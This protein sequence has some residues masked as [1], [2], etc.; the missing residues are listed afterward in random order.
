MC[1]QK[2]DQTHQRSGG[3]CCKGWEGKKRAK[4]ADKVNVEY[5]NTGWCVFKKWIQNQKDFRLNINIPKGTLWIL[6]IGVMVSCQNVG[7][8]L[9]IMWFKKGCYQNMSITKNVLLNWYS[10]MKKSWERFWWFL[11]WKID[12]EN[13]IL[14]IFV[15][16][17]SSER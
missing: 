12:F 4:R 8:I 3:C 9:V 17:W 16:S 14:V 5:G 11:T 15:N 13:Q 2:T 6:R 7:I 10:S 1:R